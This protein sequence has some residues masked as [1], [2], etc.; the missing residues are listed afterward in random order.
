M[1]T[2]FR[3]SLTWRD[4]VKFAIEVY[5]FI[6]RGKGEMSG[7]KFAEHIRNYYSG[8]SAKENADGTFSLH[9][10]YNEGAHNIADC[11]EKHIITVEATYRGTKYRVV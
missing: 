7:K 11:V 10:A 6:I 1:M 4:T 8:E 3:N 9:L 5:S 2:Q